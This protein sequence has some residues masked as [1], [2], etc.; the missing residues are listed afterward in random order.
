MPGTHLLHKIKKLSPLDIAAH[1]T[2]VFSNIILFSEL[3]SAMYNCYTS[4][5]VEMVAC[6]MEMCADMNDAFQ[7]C[8]S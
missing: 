8:I 7:R 1:T 2:I 6:V 3:L 5:I 4:N